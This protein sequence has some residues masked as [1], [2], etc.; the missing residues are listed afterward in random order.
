MKKLFS[1]LTLALLTMSA[2]ADTTVTFTAG[3][4][5]GS[6]TANGSADQVTK[7]GITIDCTDAAFATAQYRFYAGSTTTI[8][9]TVGTITSIEFTCTASGTTK[10]GP[11]CWNTETGTYAY[12]GKI[13]TWTGAAESLD[14]AA[15]QQVRATQIVV[16]VSSDPVATC[17]A[18]TLAASQN[19]E[20]TFE[21]VIT[22]N[23]EGAT[24]SYST[25]EQATWNTYENPFTIDATTTVYAKAAKDG[26]ESSVVSATYTLL[27]G[28]TTG[29][30]ATFVA[31]TDTVEGGSTAGWH[32]ITKD[33][34]T[35]KFYGT[36]SNYQ[37]TDSLGNVTSE[38]HEYRIHKNQ[39]INFTTAAGNIRMIEF[40]CSSS[41]P[42]SGFGTVE[43]MTVD[44]DNGTWEGNTRD[45]TFSTSVKQVR[46]TQIVVTLDDQI[47]TVNAPV[48][49]PAT[50]KFAGSQEVTI[51]CDTEGAQIF[52]SYDGE[53][54]NEYTEALT[55]TETTTVYAYAMK[56]GVQSETVSAVYTKLPEV[57]TIAEANALDNKTDFAFTGNVVAVYQNKSNLWVKDE[58]GY[59]LI[60]GNQVPAIAEGATIKAG[61][62]AQY[63]LFRSVIHEYQF[64]TGIEATDAE[65]VEIVPEE[66]TALTTDNINERVI[67][68]DLTLLADTANAK[69]LYNAA[70][71]L[72][73]Y[74][75][76]EIEYPTL[77]EGKTYDV[78]GMVSYYNNQVQIMPIA[79]TEHVEEPSYLRGDVNMDGNIGIAD[80][81]ALIDYILS[82][83]ATGI[84]LQA[85]DCNVDDNIGIADVTALIDY[86]LNK[87]W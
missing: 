43:G 83:D 62:T 87:A 10:Y 29:G 11:G 14:F 32:E 22:N 37:L 19:F 86:I 76:F 58:T 6:T 80:V 16:T 13:G 38:F 5:L 66:R 56:D 18:P 3:T 67:M 54:F 4:D 2:W 74:N 46:A 60:Y 84:N 12:D 51:T 20:G 30:T 70:D 75:Q 8:S 39:S 64:P 82:K 21:V 27:E 59:G 40:T 42:I 49:S 45:I 53:N 35:M 57:A 81:T 61:W 41:N 26:V 25:D 36:V 73:I 1:L 65:L 72:V 55:I 31:L 48:I 71:S 78:E 50:T 44:G 77:E 47:P 52:Y 28:Y 24:V 63:T 15:T 79:I 9:S 69:Y 33:G 34:V 17:A 23:E 85:A 7:D 68:K